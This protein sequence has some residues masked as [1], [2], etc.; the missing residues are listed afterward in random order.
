MPRCAQMSVRRRRGFAGSD[1]FDTSIP[2]R[3]SSNILQH[4]KV[5][6]LPA[7]SIGCKIL[8]ELAFH[9]L[10]CICSE[11]LPPRG[12]QGPRRRVLGCCTIWKSITM[13]HEAL[14][15][16]AAV[17][18]LVYSQC[19]S[20]S[21]SRTKLV[22]CSSSRRRNLWRCP[23]ASSLENNLVAGVACAWWDPARWIWD[24]EPCRLYL[25]VDVE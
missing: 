15:S 18:R 19:T 4:Y 9:A 10:I 24:K 25:C 13:N 17:W 21:T 23:F 14:M 16:S 12:I 3:L 11:M 7:K 22:W 20:N 1:S 6:L 8:E 5:V 2:A